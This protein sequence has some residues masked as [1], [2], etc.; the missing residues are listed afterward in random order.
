MSSRTY[1]L[2][3]SKLII[4]LKK[5]KTINVQLNIFGWRSEIY[6]ETIFYILL[7]SH[8]K[9]LAFSNRFSNQFLRV[10][11]NGL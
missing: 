3:I 10:M 7:P 6:A 4:L 11:F 2:L 8:W 9:L 5:K 1:D